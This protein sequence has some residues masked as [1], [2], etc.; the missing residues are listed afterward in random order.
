MTRVELAKIKILKAKLKSIQEELDDMP[1]GDIYVGD[2]YKDYSSGFGVVKMV[3][4]YGMSEAA[5]KKQQALKE[6][7][8]AKLSELQSRLTKMEDWLD[9]VEDEEVET[10]L[11]LKYRNGLKDWQIAEELG[12]D[13]S[14]VS[15][16]IRVFFREQEKLSP[17]SPN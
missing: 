11:R 6:R 8:A 5:Y 16:K 12:Y 3:S 14:T 17:E 4:G 1:M 2:T 15:S 7:L 13:R 10:I 9:S